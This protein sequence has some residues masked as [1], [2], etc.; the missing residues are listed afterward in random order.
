MRRDEL[1]HLEHGDLGLAAEDGLKERV[2]VDVALVLG[3]LETV[4]LD[5]VPDFF[6]ELT[7]GDRG[8]AD[9]GRENGVGLNR[10]EE[11]GIGFAFRFC[12]SWHV[13]W[14]L[15]LRL[16]SRMAGCQ[17]SRGFVNEAD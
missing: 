2:G 6:G 14:F 10:F 3:V 13:G 9:N 16:P 8:G 15:W 7:A 4:F 5:V 1:G 17:Y 12:C 11:G